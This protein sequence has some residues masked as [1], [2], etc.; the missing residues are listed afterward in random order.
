FRL[1]F[2][3]FSSSSIYSVLVVF[4]PFL[5]IFFLYTTLFRSNPQ[6]YR[7]HHGHAKRSEH[8]SCTHR[9]SDQRGRVEAVEPTGAKHHHHLSALRRCWWPAASPLVVHQCSHHF[10][11]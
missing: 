7:D 9:P 5:F 10:A 1:D 2:C 8:G 4:S 6:S 11:I 3:V